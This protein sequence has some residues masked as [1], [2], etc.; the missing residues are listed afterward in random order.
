MDITNVR[1]HCHVGGCLLVTVVV[2]AFISSD[3]TF[4][5][6]P[7]ERGRERQVDRLRQGLVPVPARDGDAGLGG[8]AAGAAVAVEQLCKQR[9]GDHRQHACGR[10]VR[11]RRSQVV[12]VVQSPGLNERQAVLFGIVEEA[13][14]EGVRPGELDSALCSSHLHFASRGK[15]VPVLV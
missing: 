6:L 9:L 1:H 12:E 11:A 4:C 13:V 8:E 7:L 5:N 2:R 14:G 10:E 15:V 3:R